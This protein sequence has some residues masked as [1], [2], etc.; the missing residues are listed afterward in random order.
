MTVDGKTAELGSKADPATQDIRVNG[1]RVHFTDTHHYLALHKPTGYISSRKDPEGRPTVM[2]LV[3]ENLRTLVYPVGRLD[4]D[5]EGLLLLFDDGELANAI[6]HPRYE[7]PKTYQA[8]VS[9]AVGPEA[10]ARMRRG[11]LLQDGPTAPAHA[12]ILDCLNSTTVVEVTIHE[13]RKRQ[14]R[15]MLEAVGHPVQRLVRVS[16]AGVELGNL[17]PGKWRKLTDAEV[18]RLRQTVATRAEIAAQ[19]P[20]RHRPSR[21]SRRLGG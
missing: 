10:L 5:S 19:A 1:R 6:M 3:P 14:V 9:G 12:R 21:T 7:I 18:E 15:R 20:T 11:M 17:K 13:G 4:A 16:I 8:L 2:E